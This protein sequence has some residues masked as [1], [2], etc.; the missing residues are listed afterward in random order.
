MPSATRRRPSSRLAAGLSTTALVLSLVGGCENPRIKGFTS[1][2]QDDSPLARDV[3]AALD[4]RPELA[5]AS[6]GVK[7]LDDGA[8]RLSGRVDDEA[9]RHTAERTAA[10][11]PGVRSVLNTLFVRD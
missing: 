8:V 6:I 5:L 1:D 11:V 4:E 9:Q 3:G 7:S 2:L 10:A